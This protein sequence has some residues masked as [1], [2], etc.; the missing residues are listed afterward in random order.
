MMTYDL[1]MLMLMFP[2]ILCQGLFLNLFKILT[3]YGSKL[4][5]TWISLPAYA[6]SN[7]CENIMTTEHLGAV[8][9]SFQPKWN[10]DQNV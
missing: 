6:S 8:G 9:I 3:Y 4:S 1:I 7:I 10:L 2:L 5:T